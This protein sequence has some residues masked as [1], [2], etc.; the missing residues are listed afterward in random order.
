[1]NN[2]KNKKERIDILAVEKGLAET[3]EKAK[4]LIMAGLLFAD[5]ECVQKPG[6]LI[7]IDCEITKKKSLSL[8]AAAAIS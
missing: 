2:K 1:M 4:R 8:S 3:R 7:P 6:K 5:G